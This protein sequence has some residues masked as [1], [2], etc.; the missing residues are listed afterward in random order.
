MITTPTTLNDPWGPPP[1]Y[2]RTTHY[3]PGT[4][5]LVMGDYRHGIW[6]VCGTSY[7]LQ[8][9]QH[10]HRPRPRTTRTSA[11]SM[12]CTAHHFAPCLLVKAEASEAL[13]TNLLDSH[14]IVG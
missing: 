7:S 11:T 10:P 13:G 14:S 3:Y 2:Y 9:A 4:S 1:H 6:G 12:P 8:P 5:N